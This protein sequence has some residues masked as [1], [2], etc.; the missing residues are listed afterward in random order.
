MSALWDDR[1]EALESRHLGKTRVT[2]PQ[3]VD[4]FLVFSPASPQASHVDREASP[5]SRTLDRHGRGH[6]LV[7][8]RMTAE[9]SVWVDAY[10][11]WPVV[12]TDWSG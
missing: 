8:G 10:I 11:T 12:F 9:Q 1:Q 2:G 4:G 7:Y 6:P 5:M 3:D